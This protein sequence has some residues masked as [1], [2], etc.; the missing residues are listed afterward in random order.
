MLQF[1]FKMLREAG[2]SFN[3][4]AENVTNG[5]Q[6]WDAFQENIGFNAWTD[7]GTPTIG[8]SGVTVD[9]GDVLI[10]RYK[11]LGKTLIWQISLRTVTISGSPS[12]FSILLPT[13]LTGATF[14][15][16]EQRFL[17]LYNASNN[18]YVATALVSGTHRL[19]IGVIGG[20]AFTNG[21]N[22][23]EF[24]LNVIVEMA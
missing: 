10:N 4:S 24:D 19:F 23:Q 22:N 6:Y 15:T 5:L 12:S 11:L 8:G 1:F 20:G 18:L 7:A 2:I 9:P 16:L 21:S 3:N 14:K 13:A 17:G